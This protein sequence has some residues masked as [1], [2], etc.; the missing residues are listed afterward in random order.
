MGFK[1]V[2]LVAIAFTALF[3][4]GV[5]WGQN[6]M[7]ATEMTDYFVPDDTIRLEVTLSGSDL[8]K[9]KE[10]EI[11]LELASPWLKGQEGWRTALAA[12]GQRISRDTVDFLI[13]V[14]KDI[15]SGQYRWR[16]SGGPTGQTEL[17]ILIPDRLKDHLFTI[18]N[19]NKFSVEVKDIKVLPIK[20]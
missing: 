6:T 5:S 16:I 7:S 2:Q 15:A 1:N 12:P 11:T 17:P 10:V 4:T 18:R 3:S 19:N 13:G 14:P 8:D 20:P 9:V